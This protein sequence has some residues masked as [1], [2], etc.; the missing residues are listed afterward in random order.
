[1]KYYILMLSRCFGPTAILCFNIKG[2]SSS[3]EVESADL[4]EMLW[5]DLFIQ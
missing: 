5:F 4:P 1:M 2:N 3:S